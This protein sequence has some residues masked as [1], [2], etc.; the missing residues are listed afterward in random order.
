MKKSEFFYPKHSYRGQ[1]KP[2]NLVFNT[3]L[4]E[5]STRV[6]YICG[7]ATNGKLS[8]QKAYQQIKTNWKH[9]KHS[10]KQLGIAQSASDHDE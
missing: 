3:N 10:K 1:A 7:L 4:Q 5:F 8:S 2:E 6:N 9:L